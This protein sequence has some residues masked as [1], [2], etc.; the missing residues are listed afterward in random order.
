MRM[1]EADKLVIIHDA[2]TSFIHIQILEV[3]QVSHSKVK[4]LFFKGAHQISSLEMAVEND[5]DD[6]ESLFYFSS[7]NLLT[8]IVQ[9][10]VIN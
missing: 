4:T 7:E 9:A 6:I 8:L 10:K 1:G 5:F 3:S 2:A